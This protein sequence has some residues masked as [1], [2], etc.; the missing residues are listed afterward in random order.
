MSRWVRMSKSK[1]NVVTPEEAVGLFGADALRI[2]ELFVAPF[3]A[4]I[5]WSSDGMAG[6]ARFLHRVFKLASELQPGYRS[7][8]ADHIDGMEDPVA[9][10]QRRITHQTIRKVTADID[11]FAFNTYISQMMV[12]ANETADLAKQGTGEAYALAASEAL[13]SLILLIAPAA[14]HSADELWESTGRSGFT[15]TATWPTA[16]DALAAEDTVTIAVQ[17]NGKLRD[18]LDA[19]TGSSDEALR[20][21]ALGSAKVQ[22][23][24]E[25]KEIRKVIVVPGKLVSI[26]VG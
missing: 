10:K 13:E 4:D 6:A 19:P 25:G 16:V 2:Y 18:T 7:D 26:V 14:P 5:Q 21:A 23:H 8:W 3:E 17:V 11:R 24:L 20:S 1:G 22:L 9:R 12:F 15:F